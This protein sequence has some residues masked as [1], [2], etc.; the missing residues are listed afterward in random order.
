MIGSTEL[1]FEMLR[2]DERVKLNSILTVNILLI[3]IL[4]FFCLT[5]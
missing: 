4:H 5:F 3:T 1:K 2:V